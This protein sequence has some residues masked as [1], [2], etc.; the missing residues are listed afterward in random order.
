MV[1]WLDGLDVFR[2]HKQG[3]CHDEMMETVLR[4]GFRYCL[5]RLNEA[6]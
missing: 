6:V 3:D 5:E 4:H 1:G 2:G